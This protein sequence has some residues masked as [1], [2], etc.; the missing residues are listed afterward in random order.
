MLDGLSKNKAP[1]TPDDGPQ[2]DTLFLIDRGTLTVVDP[3]RFSGRFTKPVK[4]HCLASHCAC[5]D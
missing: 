2:I 5:L 3:A 1:Y 4:K